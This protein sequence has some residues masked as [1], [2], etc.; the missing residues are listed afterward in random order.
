MSGISFTSI[1][2]VVRNFPGLPLAFQ[3]PAARAEPF[4][5]VPVFVDAGHIKISVDNTKV[6]YVPIL[7]VPGI[8]QTIF[9]ICAAFNHFPLS[10][11]CHSRARASLYCAVRATI[12]AN[13]I[14]VKIRVNGILARGIV[15]H[16]PWL[17][18]H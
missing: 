13:G 18:V 5:L 14:R 7:V 1:L 8:S 16:N 11:P 12:R 10:F 4:D 6:V 2:P 15:N 3:F 17:D 9:A